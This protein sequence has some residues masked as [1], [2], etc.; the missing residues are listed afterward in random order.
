[1]WAKTVNIKKCFLLFESNF[2][3]NR[4]REVALAI[5]DVLTKELPEYPNIEDFK[6]VATIDEVDEVLSYLYDWAD[7]HRVWLG[8]K[9]W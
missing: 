5:A 2:D 9:E 6:E 4:A 7:D 3:D 8:G 1:M